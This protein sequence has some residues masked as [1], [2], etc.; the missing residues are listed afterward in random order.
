VTLEI[1]DALPAVAADA[2]ALTRALW[3]LLDNAAK[4]SSKGTPV[5][6]SVR[7]ADQQVLVDVADHGI[8]I[9]RADRDR[10]FQKFVR[11]AEAGRTA[12]R[13][14]GIGLA[15]VKQIVEA[16]GGTVRVASEPGQGS[17]FTLALPAAPARVEA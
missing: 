16:H 13:G 4:Y 8:G 1:D 7:R 2:E 10:I 11:G 15:L 3:N 6:V 9:A 17:T 14:L 5:R 12:A